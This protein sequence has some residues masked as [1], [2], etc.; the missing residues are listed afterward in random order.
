LSAFTQ[1][2]LDVR[3]DHAPSARWLATWQASESVYQ[4]W[5]R[6]L[7]TAP[8]ASSAESGIA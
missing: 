6:T 3:L 4:Y 5:Y 2:A 8:D 1:P 7:A